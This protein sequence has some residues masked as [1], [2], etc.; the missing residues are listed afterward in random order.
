[1]GC[2]ASTGA[3][4][5]LATSAHAHWAELP[6][7]FSCI[8][9]VSAWVGPRANQLVI[10]VKSDRVVRAPQHLDVTS[11]GS[12]GCTK[13]QGPDAQPGLWPGDGQGSGGLQKGVW[14]CVTPLQRFSSQSYQCRSTLVGI[15]RHECRCQ[16]CLPAAA[17]RRP[18]QEL[19]AAEAAAAAGPSYAQVDVDDLLDDPDLE[20]LHAERLAQMQREAEKRVKMQQKGHGVLPPP[21]AP[22]VSQTLLPAALLRA[23]TSHSPSP[24]A[25]TAC[26]SAPLPGSAAGAYEE[27]SEGDFLEAVTKTERVVCHFFH[28]EFERCRIMDKHLGEL[29]RKHFGTRFIKLSAPVSRGG[30]GP[31]R[32]EHPH[33]AARP[34]SGTGSS[35]LQGAPLPLAAPPDPPRQAPNSGAGRPVLRG[36]AAGP[37]AAVRGDVCGRRG[38][39]PHRGLRHAGR[40]R[41]LPHHPGETHAIPKCEGAWGAA[42]LFRSAQSCP[43]SLAALTLLLARCAAWCQVEKKLLKAGVVEPPPQ[44]KD[45]SDDEEAAAQRRTMRVGLAQA[46]RRQQTQSDEDSDFE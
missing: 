6:I 10:L 20:K 14:R 22:I 18:P 33:R 4:V 25:P 1:M 15:H 37:H 11:T 17:C 46:Q 29:A 24:A 28:R 9:L 42:R 41:R 44:R 35:C 34:G 21:L 43:A 39:G 12:H 7:A 2:R 5:K 27:I 26:A 32:R 30:R 40:R 16:P 3:G 8:A 38:G 36:E 13:G 31:P 19:L 45:D 23:A